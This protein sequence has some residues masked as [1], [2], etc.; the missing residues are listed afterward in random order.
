M[1]QRTR[2]WRRSQKRKHNRRSYKAAPRA[3]WEEKQWR[4]LYLRSAKLKRAKQLGRFWPYRQWES[5]LMES[6]PIKV[7]F[8]CSMNQW[9]SPTGEAVFSEYADLQ[10]RSAGT[11]RRAKRPISYEDVR[12][13]DII[14]VMEDKHASRLR[15]EFRDALRYKP[16][17]VLDIPDEFQFMDD[18][19][20]EL[21]TARATP[22]IWG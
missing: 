10:V 12:W 18:E 16:V 5:H 15:A 1:T 3:C 2:D 20:V 4:F 9:R 14:L 22:L 7:L 8:V 11:A 21:I 17:H 13:S 6:D 19:L